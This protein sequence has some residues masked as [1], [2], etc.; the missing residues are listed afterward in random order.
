MRDDRNPSLYQHV[1][2]AFDGV[3]PGG[4]VASVSG[5][6]VLWLFPESL[7]AIPGWDARV[8][9]L[10]AGPLPGIDEILVGELLPQRDREG[11]DYFLN[12]RGE[13]CDL[14]GRPYRTIIDAVQVGNTQWPRF[15]N[16]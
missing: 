13:E 1:S 11:Y 16:V 14:W 3:H 15:K 4:R 12:A 8:A 2:T 5:R 7:R 9:E 6:T 10:N